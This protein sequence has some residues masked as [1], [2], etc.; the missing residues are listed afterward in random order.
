MAASNG[1]V[2]VLLLLLVILVALLSF[3]YWRLNRDTNGQYTVR[4]MV[5]GK[6]GL[7]DRMV[8]GVAAMETRLGVNLLPRPRTG[9]DGDGEDARDQG[10]SGQLVRDRDLE[11]GGSSQV[12]EEERR[13]RKEEEEEQRA[14][15]RAENGH[16]DR[17]QEEEEEDE[18]EDSEDDYSSMGGTDLRVR[19]KLM[20]EVDEEVEEQERDKR[21]GGGEEEKTRKE[22]DEEKEEGEKRGLLVNLQEF[23]GSAIWSGE[24]KEAEEDMDTDLTAL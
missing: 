4:E 22:G 21:E 19:A 20:E 12:E 1:P 3:L 23:S 24:T 2:V 6:D 14:D 7:R 9:D 17:R 15:G 5:L 11:K 13:R 8:S 18:E 10:S 16:T